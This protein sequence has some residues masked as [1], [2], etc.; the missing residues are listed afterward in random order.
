MNPFQKLVGYPR[1]LVAG[2]PSKVDAGMLLLA[3]LSAIASGIPFPLIGILFGQLIDDFNSATC[4]SPDTSSARSQHQD[5]VNNKIL[6]IL[7]LAIAQF[8]TIYM[9]L[10]CWSLNGARLA[11]RLRESY[12]HNLLRQEPSYFDNLPPGE[13][14]SRLNGDIQAIRSGTSEKVGI[15]LSSLS[16][17]ITAYIV[18][19][20]KDYKLAAM[21]V[22]LIPAYFLMSFVGSHYV[23]KYSGLMSDYAATA[24]SI[25][26]EAL[27]NVVIVHAFR[28]NTRLENKFS[29][30][31]KSSEHEGLKKALAVG[32]QSGVLYFIAYSANGLAFWQAS[33]R[34]AD[35]VR[36]DAKTASVGVAFTVVFI[37]IEATLVLSQVAPFLH[38]FGAAVASFQ[39]LRQDMDREPLIDGTAASGL[40]LSRAEGSFE[41]KDVSFTYPSRPEVTVLD[42]VNLRIPPRKHTAIVGFSGSGKSTIAALLTRLYDPNQ[43]QVLFDGHNL[44]DLN[45][46][47]LRSFLSLVQQDPSLLDR[48]ILENIAHGLI[49]S[50]HPS[51]AHLKTTLLGPDLADLASQV[52]EGQDLAAA[53][54]KLG[55]N[56]VEIISLVRKAAELADADAFIVALQHGYGTMVG[57]SGRLIS[58]GQK[59]RVALARALVKDPRVL[60]LDEATA[61]LDSRS[62]RRIQGA[63]SGIA[64]GRTMITIAHRLSTITGADNI[65]VMQKGRI[66]EEGTHSTLMAKNGAYADLVRL[67]TLGSTSEKNETSDSTSLSDRGSSTKGATE[68]GMLSIDGIGTIEKTEISTSQAEVNESAEEREE[69]ETPSKALWSLVRGFTPVLR[70][71]LLIIV[72]SLLASSVVGGS[73]SAEAVIF[74]NTV[75]SLSP[76]QSESYIRSRGSFLGLMFFIL[77]IIEFFANVTS[78]SGFGW[79]AEKTVYTV[80]VLSFRSLFGQDLQWHQSEGRTPALLLSY[81]TRDGNALGGLSGSVIGTLFSITVNLIAAI[82]LTHIIAWKIALVCLSLVPLLLGAGLMEL[83]VLARFEERHENAYTKSVDIGVE[84]ITSI[85]TIA[86]LSLEAETL[87]TYR[88]SLKGPRKETLKVSLYA[89]LWLAMT[90]LLGN[91]VN[92]LAYWWGAKQIIAG[93]YTQTQFM[94]VVFSL[95]V[96]ALLWSQM[97]ALAPELTSA[98]AAVAR[99]LGLIEIG[100]DKMQGRVRGAPSLDIC[101]EDKDLEAAAEAKPTLPATNRGSSVQLRDVHFAYPSR[102]E[103]EVLKGLNVEIRPGTLCALVGPSG[104]GK[105][106]IISLVERLY[107]PQSGSIIVDGVDLTKTRDVSF[108]DTIALVPQESVLFEGTIEFNIGLGAR[109]GHETTMDEIQEACKLANIHDTIQSLPDGYQTLCGPN[110]NQFS[111]GQKQ[112]LSIAR[113]LVRKPK[114]LILDEPTSALDAE[115]EKLLQDGLEKAARGITVIAIAHR[116]HT[117]RKANI[118][119][120]I[121]GGQCVDRGTHEELL[122]RSESYRLNVMHQTLAE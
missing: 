82:V 112:R 83:R 122:Q 17:F 103:V 3:I 12:L 5:S 79:V 7:Y 93:N 102:P 6:L 76:C 47:D 88:R 43:G 42:Q 32:V 84:A 65:I 11:Q 120:L 99:L 117:I 19:F 9:H 23:E 81:I 59:Q 56:V 77:A 44:R 114:L 40:R 92:A 64:S 54:E 97:F 35:A 116:L 41:F 29:K 118:I 31:L 106:T 30:A 87:K 66:L 115:S 4:D 13:V 27:S 14:A 57:S 119:F 71:H 46:H 111:G 10:S 51:H 100:P 48:S 108:R 91:L 1:L 96:S 86:S 101:C 37:L 72:V 38:L 95:L 58:G 15:C 53:A 73:F 2:S 94:I 80:R 107:T 26:S 70:P 55:S 60:I 74:G 98:R 45:L 24:A 16:F 69:P 110:G 34:I 22:S 50:S 89:S 36:H 75:G 105:S 18:A 63:I 21:L 25:A 61:S 109:P 68:E 39:K 121:E 113:A 49:N 85:K 20:I 67:Q 104:A 78:W 52:R 28:A 90:Y 8:V 33:R 62:E